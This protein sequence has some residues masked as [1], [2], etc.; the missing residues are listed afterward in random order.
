VRPRLAGP[1]PV[2]SWEDEGLHY[3]VFQM[4]PEDGAAEGAEP[5]VALFT[6]R[7]DEADPA[8]ALVVAL[9]VG[10]DEAVFTDLRQPGQTQRVSLG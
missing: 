9:E 4:K 3:F 5:P 10:G 6:M 1:A 2:D 8:G 7:R